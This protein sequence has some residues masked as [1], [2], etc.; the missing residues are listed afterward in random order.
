MRSTAGQELSYIYQGRNP[1]QRTDGALLFEKYCAE[2]HGKTGEGLK[3]PALNNQEFLSAASN[4][5]L[6]ATITLGRTGPA[7]PSWGY[8]SA[9]RPRLSGSER[10][11]LVAHIRSYQRI[12]LKY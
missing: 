8:G 11:D 6:L 10:L 4:G 2:C 5:Y 3:A 9:D 1:G 7:M 12:H